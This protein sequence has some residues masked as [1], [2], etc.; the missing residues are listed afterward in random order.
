MWSLRKRCAWTA[1]DNGWGQMFCLWCKIKARVIL[2][3]RTLISLERAILGTHFHSVTK[4]QTHQSP[5]S[6][7]FWLVGLDFNPN[8]KSFRRGKKLSRFYPFER[9]TEFQPYRVKFLNPPYM[10]SSWVPACFIAD[11][12]TQLLSQRQPEHSIFNLRSMGWF[13]LCVR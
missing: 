4:R 11:A 3:A 1:E 10:K 7:W 8:P 5:A 12:D 2:C 9:Y 6:S 13:F